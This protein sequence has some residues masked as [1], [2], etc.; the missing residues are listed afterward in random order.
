[1]TLLGKAPDM[2]MIPAFPNVDKPAKSGPSWAGSSSNQR[3]DRSCSPSAWGRKLSRRP[4]LLDGRTAT[5]HWGDIDRIEQA[6]PAVKWVRGVRY[7]DGGDY[8]TSAGITSGHRC[9]PPLHR[10]A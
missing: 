1:M 8:M 3:G 6:Y 5:T 7:V 9:S 10:A 4:G 2:V